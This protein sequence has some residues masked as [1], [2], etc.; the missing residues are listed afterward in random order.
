MA[1]GLVAAPELPEK[2]ANEL[3]GELPGLLGERVDARVSW[4]VSVLVD[5]LTGAERDA[6]E[7]LD[8]CRDR[9][10][11]E[12]YDLSVCLTDL[13]IYRDGRLVVADASAAREVAVLSLP[14][15]GAARVRRRALDVALQLVAELYGRRPDLLREEE[16]GTEPSSIL[17]TGPGSP[18][19]RVEPP[20]E[21]MERMGVDA[22]FL[23]PSGRGHPR[24]L[25]GM[26]LSSPPSKAPSPQPSPRAPTPS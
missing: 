4:K 15:L 25:A 12:G 6:S 20:D 16:R 21:D 9:S 8:E 3:A 2:V 26:V 24:L 18:V 14:A 10:R 7:I 5:P 17:P 19:R 11:K 22:R 23:S 13:P 1:L